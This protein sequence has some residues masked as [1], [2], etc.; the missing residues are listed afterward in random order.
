MS[1][2]PIR[3]HTG[4]LWLQCNTPRLPPAPAVY[5][6][7]HLHP[8]TLSSLMPDSMLLTT[9]AELSLSSFPIRLFC[10]PLPFS[11]PPPQI[12]LPPW[13]CFRASALPLPLPPVC[14]TLVCSAR[15]RQESELAAPVIVSLCF[16][17]NKTTHV[18]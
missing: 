2:L 6:V 13:R 17:C 10:S 9:R 5:S 4:L 7:F 18:T 12:Q 14:C 11:L 15:I 8:F 1:A 3:H 16:R